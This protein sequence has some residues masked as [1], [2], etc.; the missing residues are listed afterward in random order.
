MNKEMKK[1]VEEEIKEYFIIEE[2]IKL[3]KNL[4]IYLR[5]KKQTIENENRNL[6]L[7][8]NIY[9]KSPVIDGMPTA[10]N[11]NTS[12]FERNIMKQIEFNENMIENIEENIRNQEK[13]IFTLEIKNNNMKN[14]LNI[15]S[16]EDKLILELRYNKQESETYIS[17]KINLSK[18]TYHRIKRNLIRSI[19]NS[20]V[21]CKEI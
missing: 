6:K 14:I 15:L 9:I 8:F 18:S 16:K 5:E 21:M 20:L 3:S 11:D 10:N 19:Y 12:Y 1:F 4:I 17:E 13:E 7:N 2:R